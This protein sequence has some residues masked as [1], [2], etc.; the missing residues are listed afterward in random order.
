MRIKNGLKL[1]T[2]INS[3]ELTVKEIVDILKIVTKS[4]DTIKKILKLG[5]EKGL[6]IR[7]KGR[8]YFTSTNINNKVDRR[9]KKFDCLSNCLRCGKKIRN[10]YYICF[11]EEKYGPFGSDCMKKIGLI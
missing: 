11:E 1:L 7:D 3:K 2:Y 4:P 8:I 6:I 9:I 5:E 10:C